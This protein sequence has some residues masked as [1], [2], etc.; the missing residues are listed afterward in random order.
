MRRGLLK[1]PLAGVDE[2]AVPS[3]PSCDMSHDQDHQHYVR[4]VVL[5]SGKTIEVVYFED[6][7][8]NAPSVSPVF[9]ETAADLHVCGTCDSELVYPVEW[10]EAGPRAL[11]GHAALPQLR[12]GRQRR[13]R[14]GPRRALRRG[15]R[16]RHRGPRPR[17]AP[18]DAREHG[19][20]DR[21]VRGR[22]RGRAHP[23]ED[24]S[25][26]RA[27]GAVPDSFKDESGRAVF[28]RSAGSACPAADVDRLRRSAPRRRRRRGRGLGAGRREVAAG[29]RPWPRRPCRARAARDRS[30]APVAAI[31]SQ[32]S[33]ARS[34]VAIAA[35]V[36]RRERAVPSRARMN[37]SVTVP[38]SRS[39]PRCLP[40]ARPARRR[41][42]RRRA[43][44]RRGRCAARR[45]RAARAAVGVPAGR[46]EAPSV[47]AASNSRAVFSSQRRR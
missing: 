2:G 14:A 19:G 11:G 23:A 28:V 7:V 21:P 47:H 20:R 26:A 30:S 18:P 34:G 15:A 44:G 4:R 10:D 41:R 35:R 9:D 25:S 37:G 39:V 40:C 6:Q 31:A 45:R 1:K 36:E 16:P 29:A 33:A 22:P 13:L 32:T 42:G 3:T 38:S 8:V 12:V 27:C 5:P 17:P 24:F 43:S 46:L